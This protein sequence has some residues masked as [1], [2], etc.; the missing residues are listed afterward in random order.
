MGREPSHG[1]PEHEAGLATLDNGQ[2][3]MAHP[4]EGAAAAVGRGWAMAIPPAGRSSAAAPRGARRDL[5]AVRRVEPLRL[6]FH[7]EMPIREIARLWGTDAG[8]L[9]HDYARARQEFLSALRDVIAGHHPGTADDVDRECA[10][11]LALL[12]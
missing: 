8:P 1:P 2:A 7:E 10:Q 5:A 3:G 4:N 9:H 6:R 11:L 12:E